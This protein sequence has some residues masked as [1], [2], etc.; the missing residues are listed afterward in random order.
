M[1]DTENSTQASIFDLLPDEERKQFTPAVTESLSSQKGA[2][3]AKPSAATKPVT[4]SEP[5]EY[6]RDRLVF[7]AGRRL[8]VP[9][10]TMKL[11]DVRAWLEE[12][13]PELSKERTEMLYDPETGHVVPVIRGHK[14][15]QSPIPVYTEHPDEILPV[16]HFL[17]RHGRVFE[18]RYTQTGLFAAPIKGRAELGSSLMLFVPK[19]PC[20]ILK[21][22]VHV[23]Q[24]DPDY[25][26]L[27]YIL[28]DR[29]EEYTVLWPDQQST[30][31]SV[32][33][34]GYME[35]EDRFIAMQIHSHGRLQAYF[36]A[37]DD[38]DEVRSGLYGVVGRCDTPFPTFVC[39]YSCGGKYV[40]VNP[41]DLFAEDIGHVVTPKWV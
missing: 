9:G 14:K 34:E 40:L 13:F 31:V 29:D 36:S 10:R 18:I 15:G 19:V 27:A 3:R 37:Q 25:E 22:I 1:T 32:E 28:W 8:E 33:A 23:F 2:K 39:R 26:H 35:T 5:D 38:A 21:D 6:D 16:Y 20:S 24:D 7:Y 41:N 12:T 4:E 17:D 11:E 30:N